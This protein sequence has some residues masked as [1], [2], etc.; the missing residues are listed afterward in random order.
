MDP[1]RQ[2]RIPGV[3]TVDTTN[4][5]PSRGAPEPRRS[6]VGPRKAVCEGAIVQETHPTC[7]CRHCALSCVTTTHR[8][9]RRACLTNDH[10]SV[11]HDVPPDPVA[12]R[13]SLG[14]GRLGGGAVAPNGGGGSFHWLGRCSGAAWHRSG[15]L[16]DPVKA[17]GSR[18]V[19]SIRALGLPRG[20]RSA[21]VGA[22][23]L[24]FLAVTCGHDMHAQAR[25]GMMLGDDSDNTRRRA[26]GADDGRRWQRLGTRGMRYCMRGAEKA[27]CHPPTSAARIPT[28]GSVAYQA[29]DPASAGDVGGWWLVFCGDVDGGGGGGGVEKVL[30]QPQKPTFQLNQPFD[31]TRMSPS[32]TQAR[33]AVRPSSRV[34]RRMARRR[35]ASCWWQ[36]HHADERVVVRRAH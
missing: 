11:R 25:R 31:E 4:S 21:K 33:V 3:P 29:Q 8:H 22:A 5:C 32:G 28:V 23:R 16:C 14:W 20:M 17:Y 6:R 35:H 9:G 12:P 10:Q 15:A 18:C 34:S 13:V 26:A 2:A 30:N 1:S 24:P 7:C 19:G 36:Q 27:P